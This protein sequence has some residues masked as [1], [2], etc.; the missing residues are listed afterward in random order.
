MAGKSP[1]AIKGIYLQLY[2]H[3][4][5][6]IIKDHSHLAHQLICLFPI[7]EQSFLSTKCL[8]KC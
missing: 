4:A 5:H 2:L 3:M 8:V 6:D 7:K 1:P